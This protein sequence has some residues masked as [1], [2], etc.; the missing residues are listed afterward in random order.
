MNLQALIETYADG[1]SSVQLEK[2][3]NGLTNRETIKALRGGRGK[4]TTAFPRPDTIRGLAIALGVTEKNIVDATAETLGLT[5]ENPTG[6]RKPKAVA[7]LE[8][9]HAKLL[10]KLH[11]L[12]EQI[13]YW[14]NHAATYKQYRRHFT[15][16]Q[17]I[18]QQR[19]WLIA[20]TQH[21]ANH[22]QANERA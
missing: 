7:D 6:P 17:P 12:Q 19:P 4:T 9:Q 2:D 15:R 3:S 20:G 1:R 22:M 13:Y 8:E 16:L 10:E 5:A 21:Q 11:H 14:Q 18:A